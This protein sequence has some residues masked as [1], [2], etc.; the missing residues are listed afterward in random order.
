M[1]QRA[2]DAGRNLSELR[3]PVYTRQ[4]TDDLS[5]EMEQLTTSSTY[6]NVSVDTSYRPREQFPNAPHFA[7]V[8]KTLAQRIFG[9]RFAGWRFGALH[10]AIW[11]TIVF[12][13]NV[14]ATAWNLTQTKSG[15]LF[16]G[17][18]DRIKR[19]NTGLHFLINALS[20]IL[21]SGSNY[22]MQCLSAPTRS[23]VD[24]AH[25]KG[26]WLDIGIP[27]IRN[28]RHLSRKRIML[29]VLLTISSLPLH[30]L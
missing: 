26:A 3:R 2:I 5:T 29:W 28:V 24:K 10:F 22:C 30:L 18:C 8:E 27:S 9:D 21:L 14:A 12:I 17:D 23:E 16:E 19:L 20:T 1:F 7:C 13:I 15:V 11:A 25:R 6:G 4:W